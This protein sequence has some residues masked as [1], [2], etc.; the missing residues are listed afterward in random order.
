MGHTYTPAPM[1][2]I[3]FPEMGGG[4]PAQTN[5]KFRSEKQNYTTMRKDKIMKN[6]IVCPSEKTFVEWASRED[7]ELTELEAGMILGYVVGHGYGVCLDT[8]DT[9]IVIDTEEPENGIVARGL[10]E[11]IERVG[12][13]NY[14]LIQD[15]EVTGDYHEQVIMDM[16]TIDCLLGDYRTDF[17]C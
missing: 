17:L 7:R 8:T 9:I 15:S 12:S 3:I 16:E 6:V 10:K 4:Y 13:W 2:N 5:I 11:L 14:E 1:K